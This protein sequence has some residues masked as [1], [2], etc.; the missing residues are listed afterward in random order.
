M[1]D[2]RLPVV[3]HDTFVVERLGRESH[4]GSGNDHRWEVDGED[5]YGVVP[6][7]EYSS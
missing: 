2:G 4:G 1:I 5:S 3:E 7:S 6:G